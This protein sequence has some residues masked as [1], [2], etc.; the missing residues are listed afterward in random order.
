ME[1]AR[2]ALSFPFRWFEQTMADA[3]HRNDRVLLLSHTPFGINEN[4]HYRLFS[5]E[6]ERKLLSVIDRYSSQIIMCLTGHLHQDMIRLYLTEK[7]TLGILSHPAIS[8]I[9]WLTNPSIRRYSYSRTSFDLI[10]YD[11]YAL[12]LM[13]TKQSNEARWKFTY[14]FSS[15]Y[16]QSQSLSSDT[17]LRLVYLIRTDPF[18]LR[19]FLLLKHSAQTTTLTNQKILHTLCALTMFNFDEMILCTRTLQREKFFSSNVT[20]MNN[21][22]E[23]DVHRKEQLWQYRRMYRRIAPILFS[24]LLVLSFLIQRS[25]RRCFS[26]PLTKFPYR[27]V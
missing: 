10:D 8:P 20:T 9:S 18:Y 15:W 7:S 1:L 5:I 27:R 26:S 11:Q 12:N 16:Q 13:E 21:S 6:H 14:R 23:F 24:L 25:F 2:R 17:L 22:L 4:L 19:R 3:F